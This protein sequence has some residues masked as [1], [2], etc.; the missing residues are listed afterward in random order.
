MVDD[1]DAEVVDA[2]EKRDIESEFKEIIRETFDH[3]GRSFWDENP[4]DPDD[5][6]Y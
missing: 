5:D 3:L 4:R 2:L 1:C 6:Q